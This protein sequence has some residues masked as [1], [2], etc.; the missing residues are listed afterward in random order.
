MRTNIRRVVLP[1]ER[2][3][4]IRW[5][6]CTSKGRLCIPGV[7]KNSESWDVAG[8]SKGTE[9]SCDN[10]STLH[11]RKC[12]MFI[13]MQRTCFWLSSRNA[14]SHW[15]T[16]CR[17]S[18]KC[19][20]ASELRRT[21]KRCS[22]S[23]SGLTLTK[24]SKSGRR[25]TAESR[26]RRSSSRGSRLSSKWRRHGSRSKSTLS[27]EKPNSMSVRLIERNVACIIAFTRWRDT[28]YCSST[29]CITIG[30]RST[31]GTSQPNVAEY[32]TGNKTDIGSRRSYSRI[33][34]SLT[35]CR[36]SK[37]RFDGRR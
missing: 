32:T 16:K 21:T 1:S 14:G 31:R 12:I 20:F 29:K 37:Q 27:F 4:V 3:R 25:R 5:E 2:R 13:I 15:R 8:S 36:T 10:S 22:S 28:K 6:S 17:T 34:W 30:I 18:T 11:F 24:R 7:C 19:W 9:S 26:R 23:K 35:K 33:G